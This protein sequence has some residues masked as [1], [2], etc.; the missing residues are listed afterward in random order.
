VATGVA[1][2]CWLASVAAAASDAWT[3]DLADSARV[4]GRVVRLADVA[5]GA[6]PVPCR[7][8]VVYAGGSPGRVVEIERRGI[9]RRLVTLGLADGVRLAGA[10]VCRVA[11]AGREVSSAE[12]TGAVREALADWL[13]DSPPGAPA[14]RLEVTLPARQLP[15]RGSWHV[16]LPEP[17]R[18]QPGRNL[19]PVAVQ[20]ADSRH[21]FTAEVVLHAHAEVPYVARP[22]ASGAELTEKLFDWR[23]EDLATLSAGLV[24]G[25]ETIS[26]CS[27]ARDLLAGQPVRRSELQPTPLVHGGERVELRIRRG[28]VSVTVLAVARR[29]GALDENVPVRNEL[30]GRVVTAKV[31]G[32]GLV[33]WR[34]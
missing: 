30:T 16:E 10:P 12:L 25:R 20:G 13:P 21:R 33:D 19:V 28:G 24:A 17:R 1:L 26:G 14:T 5:R 31:T 2:A 29:S 18:L 22:V 3:L 34:P 8:V 11:F 7:D 6:L 32:P 15:L 9:L 27:A 4:D 23:W